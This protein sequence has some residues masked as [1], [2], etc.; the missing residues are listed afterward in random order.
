MGM[1][2]Q[3][4]KTFANPFKKSENLAAPYA[5]AGIVSSDDFLERAVVEV[6]VFTDSASHAAGDIPVHRWEIEAKGTDY[7]DNFSAAA[8]DPAG[9]EQYKA[10]QAFALT[11]PELADWEAE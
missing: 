2:L 3:G 9:K 1:V 6:C 7:T 10:A 5:V 4:G 11:Q 8:L